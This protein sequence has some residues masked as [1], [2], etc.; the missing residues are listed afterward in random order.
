MPRPGTTQLRP[1][2]LLVHGAWHGPWCW[3]DLLPILSRHGWRAHTV[4][5]PSGLAPGS[6]APSPAPGLYD[7]AAAIAGKLA[8]IEEPAVVVA[9]SY[10]GAPATEACAQV[11]NVAHLIYLAAFQLDVGE[12]VRTSMGTD[13]TLPIP[14]AG[15]SPPMHAAD[16]Y[17]D[18][19]HDIA[20]RATRRLRLQSDPSRAQPVRKA[21]WRTIGSS[22]V[23]CDDD[24][25][26]PPPRQLRFAARADAIH[27]LPTGHSPFYSA[28]VELADLVSEIVCNATRNTAR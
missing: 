24:K 13:P 7:D 19:S 5:L 9:H 16:F 1:A 27:H 25:A 10:G 17:S 8:E 21:G 4:D 20:A 3:E 2:L 14:D 23:V 15:Y 26:I 28:P 18:V 6:P 12:S 22:Y 11:S